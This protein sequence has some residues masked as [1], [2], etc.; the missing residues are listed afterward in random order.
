VIGNVS[1]SANNQV[2]QGLDVGGVINVNHTNVIIRQCY[3]HNG[4]VGDSNFMS[5]AC[6]NLTGPTLIEDCVI[7]GTGGRAFEG[8]SESPDFAPNNVTLRRCNVLH[9]ENHFATSNTNCTIIDNWFHNAFGPDCD[10]VEDSGFSNNVA[11]THNTFDGR[12]TESGTFL[13][14][15]VKCTND[16]AAAVTNIFIVNN[17]FLN[18]TNVGINDDNT[19]SA[20][21][22]SFSM[23]NNGFWNMAPSQYRR[24]STSTILANSGNFIMANP[25]DITGTLVNGGT[26]VIP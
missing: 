26:G 2:I 7:D 17:A 21:L 18:C 24:G 25:T 11:I 4:T 15:G 13:N 6:N 14:S 16:F 23:V 12:D 19:H 20:F 1:T 22:V 5:V 9:F 10:M 3:I 8:I